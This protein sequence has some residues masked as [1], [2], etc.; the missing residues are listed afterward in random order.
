MQII[1]KNE[2]PKILYEE[3]GARVY[4]GDDELMLNL[5]KYQRDW[6]VHIDICSNR[7]G[8]LVVGTGEGLYYVAQLDVPAII[9]TEPPEEEIPAPIPLDMAAVTLTLWNTN[10]PVPAE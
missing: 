4:F 6:S 3:S 8:Q 5:S 10:N 9:Y 1:E 2:G 7:D